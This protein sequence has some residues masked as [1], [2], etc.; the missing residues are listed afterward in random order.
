MEEAG[1]EDN[2]IGKPAVSTIWNPW[3]LPDTEPASR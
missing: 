2:P 1:E 3:E